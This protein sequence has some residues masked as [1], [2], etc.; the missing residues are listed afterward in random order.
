MCQ[1]LG[2]K[3]HDEISETIISSPTT[4]TITNISIDITITITIMC[5]TIAITI[6]IICITITI[7][8]TIKKDRPYARLGVLHY[9]IICY[10]FIYEIFI[11]QNWLKG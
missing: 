2:Q 6:T 1:G 11:S 4:I 9:H 3:K 7:T 5:V 10:L 8:I